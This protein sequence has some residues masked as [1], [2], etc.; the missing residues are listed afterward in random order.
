MC[1]HN[2]VD[3][4]QDYL[5]R[6]GREQKQV[7]ENAST[8]LRRS[9]TIWLREREAW[10]QRLE[11]FMQRQPGWQAAVR[12]AVARRSEVVSAEYLELYD[13]NLGVIHA[14]V[15]EVLNSRTEAQDR[16]LR[17]KLSDLRRDL[18]TLVS[19]GKAKAA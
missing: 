19:Q 9:D 2:L 12:D 11:V 1:C 7:L 13:H 16:R 8:Q 3:S 10:L 17:R 18:E 15:A 5:G 6:L 14:A 4:M